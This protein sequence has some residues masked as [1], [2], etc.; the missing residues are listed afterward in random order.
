MVA[1][2]AWID[3]SRASLQ[4][5]PGR[6]Q[7]PNSGNAP[8]RGAA[9][10][11]RSCW[12]H[13]TAASSSR[14]TAAGLSRS[15]ASTRRLS[16]T[17][18]KWGA[19][20]GNAVRVWRS[21]VGVDARANV[22]YPAAVEQT[23]QSLAEILKR[24]GA[25][26]AMELDINYEWVTFN[27]YGSWAA[28]QPQK[29]LPTM[30]RDATRYLTPDDRDFRRLRTKRRMKLRRVRCCDGARLEARKQQLDPRAV[31]PL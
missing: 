13:S 16:A 27:F 12:R 11:A 9:R 31:A 23:A 1:A 5:D 15:A 4:L 21:G 24:A 2:V 22:I 29:L 7:P 19:A 30:S 3:S 8:R 10:A 26:R 14:T 6:Y 25:V 18:R 20:L 28:S 17:D